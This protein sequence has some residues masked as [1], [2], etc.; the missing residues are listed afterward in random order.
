MSLCAHSQGPGTADCDLDAVRPVLST[1]I[2]AKIDHLWGQGLAFDARAFTGLKRH[3][4][5]GFDITALEGSTDDSGSAL[6]SARA[7]FRWRDDAT[8]KEETQQIGVGLLFWCALA[9]ITDAVRALITAAGDKAIHVV[10]KR[11]L[12]HRP[13][14]FHLFPRHD[15]PPRSSSLWDQPYRRGFAGGRGR[16]EG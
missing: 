16:P 6:E 9:D 13:D 3:F 5:R 11:L 4:M 2:D 1:M 15:R 12:I 10:N 8:E 14:L 7:L